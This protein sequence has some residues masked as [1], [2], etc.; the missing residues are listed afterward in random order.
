[1]SLKP[2]LN[3]LTMSTTTV[4][5]T[6]AVNTAT[7]SEE[8]HMNPFRFI[9]Q[10][11]CSF[12]EGDGH[13]AGTSEKCE[14]CRGA[15][16]VTTFRPTKKCQKCKGIGHDISDCGNKEVVLKSLKETCGCHVVETALSHLGTLT[17]KLYVRV[18]FLGAHW[19]VKRSRRGGVITIHF[20]E[21]KKQTPEVLEFVRGFWNVERVVVGS[22]D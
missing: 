11:V 5:T 14:S 10:S 7:S 17:G 3:N 18:S 13:K 2:N 22:T 8:T 12:C 1:M 9:V 16:F 15:G 21:S 20:E 19:Y 6:T 4:S